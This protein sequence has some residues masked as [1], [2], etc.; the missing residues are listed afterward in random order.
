M[1]FMPLAVLVAAAVV[2]F[3][4]GFVHGQQA[5]GGPAATQPASAPASGAKYTTDW[6]SLKKHPDPR[7]FDDAKF[8]IYFHWGVYSVPAFGTEWYSRNMYVK[9]SSENKH[10][11]AKYGPLSTFGY[12]DFIPAFTAAKFN[13]DEWAELFDKA[14]ARF[15]GPVAEHADGFAL[16]DSRLTKWNAAQMGPKRDIV[17]E[18]AKAIR[19]RNMKFVVTFHHQWLWGWYPTTDQT[20]DAAKAEYSGLYGPAVPPTAFDYGNPRPRPTPEFCSMWENKAREVVDKYQPDLVYFDSRLGIIDESYRKS[21][22][23][24]YYNRAQEWGRE[25]AVTCKSLDMPHGAA[26]E[27]LECG[28]MARVTPFKWLTDDTM[29]WNSWAYLEKPDYKSANRLV[30]QLV[31]IVS[32]NG[33]L[34]LDIGPRP[35][36]TIPEPIQERLLAIGQW[37]KVNGEAI[38]GTRPFKVFGEGPTQVKEGHFGERGLGD[39]TAQ[40]IR[41]TT[42]GGVLYATVLDWPGEQVTI[43]SL[44]KS[45]ALA[46][47]EV[48]GVSLLGH[49]GKLEW[50]RDDR[51]LTVKMPAQRPCEFAFVLKI[52][53]L[54]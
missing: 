31:D 50:S 6:E 5:G 16:W 2:A 20:T 1:R 46:R 23:A 26:I 41:F 47:G 4:A 51:G 29:D 53:G 25:V 28:R 22:V 43:K 49:D 54:R 7:W 38:Y 33:N 19:K 27:D 8:G 36:G 32:K 15:A 45:S 48:T 3:V 40:D 12:K 35:D 30:D 39:F 11:L 34:M 9:G 52:V 18:L 44:A 10:H 42:K 13:P 17:G 37:L 14:G 21:F 24:H